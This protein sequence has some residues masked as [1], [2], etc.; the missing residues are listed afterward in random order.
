MSD[1]PLVSIIVPVFNVEKYVSQ[2]LESL[3]N[4]TYQNIEIIC[5][6]DESPDQSI[7]ILEKY[8]DQ[9]NRIRIVR[10]KNTGL[11]GARNTGMQFATGEYLVF[12]DSDDWIELCTCEEAVIAAMKYNADL[13]MWSYTREY[14]EKSADKLMFWDN[15]QLFSED[16]VKN[17]INRRLC[18]LYG[19]ELAHPDYANAIETA[20]GK[21]Y[22]LSILR[23]NEIQFISEREIGTEDAL[24][25][26]YATKYVKRAVYLRSCYNHYRRNNINSLTSNYK[27]KLYLQWQHLFDLMQKYIDDNQLDETFQVALK[28]RIAL[29]ILG[30]GLNVVESDFSMIK[31]CRMIRKIIGS[32][33]YID[34]YRNLEFRYF[35]FHWKMFYF[36]AKHKLSFS[37]VMFLRIIKAI[38]S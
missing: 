35:P 13:I 8:R 30:L 28:N 15:L 7:K 6:D 11:S 12:V 17:Q 34:A 21:M 9:D 27:E 14:E 18:G 31:K 19:E 22:R 3:V 10:Q 37:L 5:V 2:C 36:C 38:I 23:D 20:W 25:N 26:L 32:N 4:Q 29:S 1:S 16:G 24:F 33:R